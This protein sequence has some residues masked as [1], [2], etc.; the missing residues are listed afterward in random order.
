MDPLQACQSPGVSPL[1]TTF[2]SLLWPDRVTVVF[3][4]RL[5]IKVY[6]GSQCSRTFA[7]IRVRCSRTENFMFATSLVITP[8]LFFSPQ[9]LESK[10][11]PEM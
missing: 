4:I 11:F 3:K 8:V 2:P 9:I 1:E 6:G 10:Y 5:P 7:E